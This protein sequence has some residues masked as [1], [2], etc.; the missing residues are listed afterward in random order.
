MMLVLINL[1]LFATGPGTMKDYLNYL[2][3]NP[4][5][6]DFYLSLH[7]ENMVKKSHIGDY[8][9]LGF[10]MENFGLDFV[11]TFNRSGLVI[12]RDIGLKEIAFDVPLTVGIR[13]FF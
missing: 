1:E 13:N 4:T 5:Y 12:W 2:N 7:I 10:V 9:A 11:P 8:M 3:Q 6:Q